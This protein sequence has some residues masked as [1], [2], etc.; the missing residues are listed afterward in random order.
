M[1]NIEYKENMEEE[2]YQFVDREFNKF[3]IEN[4]VE[5]NYKPFAFIAKEDDK[6]VGL[7]TGH[8]YY[9]EV[10]IADLI[11]YE[12]HRNKHIGSKLM[13]AVEEHFRDKGFENM[14]LTTYSFQ[15][16]EFYKKCGFKVDFVRESKVNPK[17]NKYY[18][19]KY[20]K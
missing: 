6:I 17:L 9:K 8:S 16:P 1:V 19:V 14:N 12:E 18:L 13:Q 2:Y 11:V 5:C 15:A 20:F 3:A 7:L 10:Y 4:G